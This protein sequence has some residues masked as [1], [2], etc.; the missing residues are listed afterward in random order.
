VSN[1]EPRIFL[2][3]GIIQEV[4]HLPDGV[5]LRVRGTGC[6]NP[7]CQS[8]AC[9]AAK[10]TEVWTKVEPVNY[11]FR[12]GDPVWWKGQRLF[13]IR[14]TVSVQRL[15]TYRRIKAAADKPQ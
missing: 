11:A 13:W 4:V 10:R 1:N 12:A 7:H 3:W 15:G 8:L 14:P 9:R 6:G 2:R 5:D